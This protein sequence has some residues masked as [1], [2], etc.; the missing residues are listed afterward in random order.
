MDFLDSL[1]LPQSSH[2][3][4]L[5]KYLLILTYI[6]IIPYLSVLIGTTLFSIYYKR[7]GKITNNH[8]YTRL[9][10]ELVDIS[11]FNRIGTLGLGIV[12]MLSATFC[13]AQL[14]HAAPVNVSGYMFLS[15]FFFVIGLLFLYAYKNSFHLKEIFDSIRTDD[16]ADDSI[17]S[18]IEEYKNR[19]NIIVDKGGIYALIFLLITS[20][21]FVGSIKLASDSSQ[22]ENVTSIIGLIFSLK[23]WV[24]FINFLL[25]AIAVTCGVVLYYYFRPNTEQ[26]IEQNEYREIVKK[27]S[28]NAGLI[29]SLFLPVTIGLNVLLIPGNA[30]NYGI[31]ALTIVILFI[32][33]MIANFFYFMKKENSTKY[34]TSLI[35]MFIVL[36]T[37]V[38]IKD[39]LA[40]DTSTQL[41]FD[42]LAANYEEYQ[43]NLR[44]ELGL[45]VET[46]SGADIYN[47]RC[48]AC[49]QFDKKLVGPP[50]KTVLPKYEGS[51]EQ[52][53]QFILNPVKVNPEYPAMPNQGL[54]PNE[55]EAVA[56]YLIKTYEEQY[57]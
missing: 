6:I 19:S 30:L 53:I 37:S 51:K 54:K 17:K 34:S 2:H 46:I 33:I 48:I 32:V 20:F 12:P 1:V 16:S 8:N 38:I 57:K 45:T 56:E 41:Q 44:E 21:L 39:Q 28:L 23:T 35:F 4:V 3:M 27:F 25:I 5:L 31:F 14:L 7:K 9:S 55:A 36:F 15:I 52:L 26:L 47:G 13:Y 11:T 29:F 49:H 50:Y 18:D 40:F 42:R 43:A 10:K 24:A 22:W